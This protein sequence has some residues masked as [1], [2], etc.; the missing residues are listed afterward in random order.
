MRQD[1]FIIGTGGHS[2]VVIDILEKKWNVKI[3]FLLDKDSNIKQKF[4]YLVINNDNTIMS[5]IKTEHKKAK[6]IIAIGDNYTRK[7]I[8]NELKAHGI[9]LFTVIDPSA[10]IS[11][12]ALIGKGSMVM[13]GSV[14][15]NSA[16]IGEN[17]IINTAATIDHDCKLENFVHISPGVNLAGGVGIGECSHLGIGSCVIP[18]IK[19]GKNCI[20]GAG[21]VVISNIPDN[22]MAVGCPAKIIKEL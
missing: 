16:I 12:Y 21:A 5:K 2:G 19:I 1:V 20:I 4:N 18:N 9:E 13:P 22:T 8:T 3:L 7:Q 6:A 17:C 11:K 15:N 10:I 14:I